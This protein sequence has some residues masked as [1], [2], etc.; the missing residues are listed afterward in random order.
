MAPVRQYPPCERA[1]HLPLL[2]PSRDSW[3][4]SSATSATASGPT[5]L[6]EQVVEEAAMPGHPATLTRPDFPRQFTLENYRSAAGFAA[7]IVWQALE[8]LRIR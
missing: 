2:S 5:Q 8:D 4:Q 3:N 1:P 7:I 6:K